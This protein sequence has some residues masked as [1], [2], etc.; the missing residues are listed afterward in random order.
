VS[1]GGLNDVEQA[2]NPD[3]KLLLVFGGFDNAE[4]QL[5]L[6]FGITSDI[7]DVAHPANQRVEMFED[8][9]EGGR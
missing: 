2:I 6:P 1:R 9:K 8:P 5:L 3:G 4:G 7:A